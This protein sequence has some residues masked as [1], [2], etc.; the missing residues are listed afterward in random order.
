M[1]KEEFMFV[2]GGRVLNQLLECQQLDEYSTA[3]QL[4][5]NIRAAWPDTRKR[6]NATNE[7]TVTTTE[8]IP[9][10]GMKTLHIRSHTRSNGHDHQQAV[11]F[12]NVAFANGDSDSVVTIEATDGTETSLIPI[13]L[14]THNIKCRCTCMDFRFR[15]ANYNSSDKA[16]VGRPPPPYVRKTTTR[17][18]VN[19]MQVPGVCKHILKLIQ[20]LQQQGVVKS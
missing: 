16:L 8:F 7:V 17:P 2:R 1:E 3:D 4:D 11:Q 9:Y 6:Q 18:P 19:P 15:F 10:I 5:N 14:A 12:L 13:N 20:V